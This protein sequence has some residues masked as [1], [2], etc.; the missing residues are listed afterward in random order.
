MWWQV[1]TKHTTPHLLWSYEQPWLS[2]HPNIDF[3]K[4]PDFSEFRA[5]LNAEMKRLQGDGI[6]SKKKLAEVLTREEENKLREMGLLGD[7]S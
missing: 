5:S 1:H 6:G 7:A 2:G 4:D 3:F